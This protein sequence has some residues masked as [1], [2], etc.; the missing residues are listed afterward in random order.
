MNL[1]EQKVLAEVALGNTPADLVIHGGKL[2][3]VHTGEIRPAGVAIK[4][5]RIA[6][7]GDVSYTVGPR[8]IVIDASD[9]YLVPGFI[10][11][12][13]H[14]Y[15][16]HINMTE[17]AKVLLLHGTTLVSEAFYGMAL[18][19]G[20]RA[21]RFCLQELLATPVKVAFLVP[22]LAY[23]QNRELGLPV[24]PN[25]PSAEE[26]L[27]VLDWPECYGIEEPP[28][29]PIV[30]KD[31]FFLELFERAMKR[32]QVITGHAC[33]CLGK[34]LQAYVLA[35][36]ASD[37]ECVDPVEVRE[38]ARLGMSIS[39]REGSGASD[40]AQVMRANTELKIPARCFTFCGD[41]VEFLRLYEK[42][43]LDY[44]IRLA[45]SGGVNPVD[46]IRIA[47]INAAELLRVSHEV[48]SVVPGKYADVVIVDDLRE[49]SIS[50][51]IASGKVVVEKGQFCIDL[52]RPQYPDYMYGTVRLFRPLV[53]EDFAIKAPDGRQE[54]KVRVINLKDGS[55]LSDEK[56]F[57]LKVTDGL[58]NPDLTQDVLKIAMID[59][60]ARFDKVGLGFIHGV[61]L[62][63]GAL[64]S[65]Y[66]PLYENIIVVGTNDEDMLIAANRI[67]ELGGGFVVVQNGSVL[68]ELP[69]P[70]CGLLSD[71]SLDVAIQKMRKVY[72]VVRELGCPLKSPF[73]S[74]AFMAVCGEIG[75]L[76]IGHEGLFDVDKRQFVDLFV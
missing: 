40:V 8:T 61:G 73:H 54:V 29:V 25:T 18:V 11:T 58:V 49:F 74:L 6:C 20:L 13:Q 34:E 44:N 39:A 5:S 66:N 56:H 28:Y 52:K 50:A 63:S 22:V 41:E 1:A 26:M 30:E 67:V 2:V 27:K 24:A 71:E 19:A 64:A 37:H 12:H 16:A 14:S 51:V 21:V 47:T 45:I 17:Y 23:L 31:P 55:L 33:G 69:L 65:T 57:T 75:T 35:G 10:D 9:K 7:T 32:G 62:K 46:A 60:Y 36:A 72:D 70:L 38:K 68:G 3:D 15:E 43:H 76:K 59:R 4:G 48:G 42:G 53:R